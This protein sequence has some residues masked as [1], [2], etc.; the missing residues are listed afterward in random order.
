MRL[1]RYGP[2]LAVVVGA[3]AAAHTVAATQRALP[4]ATPPPGLDEDPALGTRFLKGGRGGGSGGSSGGGSRGASYGGA[5]GSN[6]GGGGGGGEMSTTAKWIVGGVAG[7]GGL[8]CLVRLRKSCRSQEAD[9]K[10]E[11]EGGGADEHELPTAV[12]SLEPKVPEAH[13]IPTVAAVAE[14]GVPTPT[15]VPPAP[16]PTGVYVPEPYVP[17]RLEGMLQTGTG[18]ASPY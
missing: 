13:E 6:G 16:A 12:A 15:E 18:T 9:S 14:P 10:M 3:L 11:N 2:S 5:R 7:I 1:T 17:G 4:I 8:A